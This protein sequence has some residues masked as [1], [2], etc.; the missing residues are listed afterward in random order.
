V[1][2]IAEA[3]H[4]LALGHQFIRRDALAVILHRDLDMLLLQAIA[5]R[6]CCGAWRS[7]NAV[8]F[9]VFDQGCKS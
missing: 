4:L 2:V 5:I 8:L 7:I 1:P 6:I 9:G 3:L